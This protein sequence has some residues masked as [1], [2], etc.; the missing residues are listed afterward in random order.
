MQQATVTGFI[1]NQVPE[2]HTTP[3]V[4]GEIFSE[5]SPMADNPDK[6]NPPV[7]WIDPTPTREVSADTVTTATVIAKHYSVSPMSQLITRRG[8]NERKR[9]TIKNA[10]DIP[11]WLIAGESMPATPISTEPATGVIVL[12]AGYLLSEGESFI[13]ESAAPLWVCHAESDASLIA[14]VSVM[15][16]GYLPSQRKD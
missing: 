3:D 15:Q 13:Y 4:E 10:S 1:P 5:E 6:V 7:V 12:A 2:H 11:V 9:C 16:E 14:I 8:N